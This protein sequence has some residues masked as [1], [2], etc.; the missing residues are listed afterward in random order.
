VEHRCLSCIEAAE[1]D[2]N[3][4]A[5]GGRVEWV[6]TCPS[7]EGT[8]VITRVKRAGISSFPTAAGLYRY[9]HER[10][11]DL[12]GDVFVEMEGT[13]SSDRDMDADEGAILVFPRRIVGRR[14][15]APD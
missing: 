1:P 11:A 13:L 12:T 3:C 4:V 7:C 15:P 8:G 5:C 6:G 10:D 14:P 2:P 9:L